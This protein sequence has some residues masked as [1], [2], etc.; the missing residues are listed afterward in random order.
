MDSHATFQA[1]MIAQC[2]LSLNSWLCTAHPPPLRVLISRQI[3]AIYANLR[4]K[5]HAEGWRHLSQCS[6]PAEETLKEANLS[7]GI[8]P[9]TFFQTTTGCGVPDTWHWNSTSEFSATVVSRGAFSNT[10]SCSVYKRHRHQ[11]FTDRGVTCYDVVRSNRCCNY[12]LFVWLFAW[13]L[14]AIS[15]QIGYIAP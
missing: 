2:R 11:G 5:S 6:P 12:K 8:C 4:T 10:G 3:Y 14:T 15:A 7:A 13:G 9:S 1:L